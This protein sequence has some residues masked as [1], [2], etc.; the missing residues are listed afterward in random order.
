MSDTIEIQGY[1]DARFMNV[2]EIFAENFKQGL[3]VGA[4]LAVTL[5]G[6]FV[7][8]LWAGYADAA[9]TRP[10]EQDT[11]V[12][13][14][15]TTKVMTTICTLMLVD[16]GLLDLDAP[17][18]KYWPEFAQNGKENLP[19]R[20]L[21]S[22]TA[23]LA[24][25][26]DKFPIEGLYDWDLCIT[27]LAAQKPWWKPG[28]KSGYHAVTFGYLL[29][30]LVR[31]ITNKSIGTFFR[32]EVAKPLNADF[33]IGLSE[34]HDSR[35]A[36]LI[37]AELPLVFK[38]LGSRIFRKLLFFNMSIKT[39]TKPDLLQIVD[40]T[41]T[42]AWRA[43]EIPAANGHGNAR[44]IARVG[45]AL[46][47]GGELDGVKL[48]S[49]AT[50]ERALEEQSY[51]K[52]AVLRTPVRFGL[53]F[54]LPCKEIPFPHP[55]TLYWGGYGGSLAMIDLDAKMSAAFAMNKM[56]AQILLD[57]RK[58]RFIDALAEAYKAL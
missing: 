3:D 34:E 27:K 56:S 16:R 8:D 33:H 10:W 15:S 9:K 26:N 55:R 57:T 25:W 40:E 19:V 5:E 30:E 47:C 13:V 37:P 12:N 6:K 52:D 14:F 2:K 35:V 41:R 32:D 31:R 36:D 28:T 1:C 44:S 38:I 51:C 24:G 17:V 53:G 22:H 21:L 7:I 42:R 46:A 18:A 20:Y 58:V 29:G 45:A 50:I 48:L 43:A 4:S 11:I 54:G 49:P 23:G 39:L